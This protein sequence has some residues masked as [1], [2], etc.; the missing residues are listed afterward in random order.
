[1]DEVL[2]EASAAGS[3][4]TCPGCGTESVRVHGRYQRSLRD[5][6]LGGAP[7][8]IRLRI[9][10]FL[11][12]AAD[13][14]RRTFAEQIDGLTSPHARYSPPLR[15]ALTCIAVAAAGRP[16]ARLAGNLGMSVG[17]DRLLGLLR[18]VS[19]PDI[20]EV[21][22]LGVDDFAL[23]RGN[24]Y[25]TILL[26][27]ATHRPID[28]LPGRDAEPLAEWLRAHPEVQIICRDRAGAYADGARTGAPQATQ[29]A[30][31]WHIWHNLGEAVDKTVT[32]HH[33]CVR[34]GLAG[35][36]PAAAQA[37]EQLPTDA[38]PP[39]IAAPSPL[40]DTNGM[41]DVCGRERRLVVRTRQRYTD[42]QQLL[43]QGHS[44]EA[45]CQQLELD[46]GTVRRFARAESVEELLVK[47]TNRTGRLDGYT[48]HLDNRFH[49]GTT[50]AVALHAE[51]RQLGFTG[52]V[53]TVRR[54]LHPLRAN[55]VAT[56]TR[57]LPSPPRPSV[58]KPRHITRWIM[59]DPNRLDPDDQAQLDK[60]LACCPELH[61]TAGHVRDFA[62]LMHK[63]RGDRLPDWMNQVQANP[64]PAFHSLITGLRRDLAAVTA[65]LTLHWSSGP[66][67]G[68]V[69]RVKTIKRQMYGRAAFSLLRKRILLAG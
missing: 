55:A 56:A 6:P 30:D 63:H 37:E 5:T 68:N 50:D 36:S 40:P 58:P 24:T 42:V 33:A 44:L 14:G 51:L 38:P 47:A 53:Q 28:V 26:D 67:E 15:A 39:A 60:A 21:T 65:G 32:A 46:R 69:N 17:R 29:V 3:S 35:P 22:V 2:I 7:V 59:S 34:S 49:A 9:R 31:R 66:V 16:G 52:S 41:L 4:A 19:E 61:A 43:T 48:E 62:D 10:R 23:R 57:R 54:Y 64:L 20:G 8:V 11:C 13:C 12:T 18:A 45:I 25:C 27:M 1:V